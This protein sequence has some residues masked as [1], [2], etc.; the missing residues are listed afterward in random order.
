MIF[1]NAANALLELKLECLG[2]KFCIFTFNS[3]SFVS[4]DFNEASMKMNMSKHKYLKGI[5]YI[6]NVF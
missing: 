1:V 5:L 2:I 6:P 4:P 3:S